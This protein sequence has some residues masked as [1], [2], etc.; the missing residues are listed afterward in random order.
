MKGLDCI[1]DVIA[2]D[3]RRYKENIYLFLHEKYVAGTHFKCLVKVL[4]MTHYM[5]L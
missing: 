3:K 2:L 4:L 5:F 1:K